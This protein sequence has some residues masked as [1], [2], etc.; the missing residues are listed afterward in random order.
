MKDM[1]QRYA[2]GGNVVVAKFNISEDH[3]H[4]LQLN[5]AILISD[6]TIHDTIVYRDTLGHGTVHDTL[7]L[8]IVSSR[9]IGKLSL[10]YENSHRIVKLSANTPN[11]LT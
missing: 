3:L 5:A 2:S 11:Y 7:S 4:I 1:K 6:V 9:H 10:I 8:C